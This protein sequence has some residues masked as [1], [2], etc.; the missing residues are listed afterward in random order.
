MSD[1]RQFLRGLP[2]F[3]DEL[4]V[5]EPG[6][7]PD[8]PEELFVAWLTDAVEAGV[9]EPHAL[10][11]STV[12]L[13]DVPDAR[14]LVLKN[15]D[16]T[17]WQFAANR[18]S[19]KGVELERSPSAALT[20]YWPE[21][22]RQVRVRGPVR[23]ASAADSAADF[24]ARSPGSRAEAVVGNQSRPLDDREELAA[25]AAQAA[26]RL[27]TDPGLVVDS[28]TLY[29]VRAGQVEFWQADKQRRHTRLQYLR[30]GEAWRRHE[31]WP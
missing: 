30:D 26:E 20:F 13:D 29:T 18:F 14:V 21:Q 11:L 4:P 19:P 12:G 9:R 2:V 28:W 31:L 1:V 16:T 3:A 22:G 10:T 24:L 23:T 5:F 25:A 27:R 8:R 17:G 6:S 7:A 15:V